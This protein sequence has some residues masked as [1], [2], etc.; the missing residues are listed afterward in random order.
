MDFKQIILDHLPDGV[1]V[2]DK[3][4]AA[5]VKDIKK[6]VGEE[7]IPKEWYSKKTIE[8]EKEK[9][10]LETAAGNSEGQNADIEAVRTALADE[11]KA[12]AATKETLE[13]SIAEEKAA[14]KATQADYAAKEQ[15]VTTRSKLPELLAQE[16]EDEWALLPDAV[17]LAADDFDLQDV[18]LDKDG[19]ISNVDEIRAKVREKYNAFGGTMKTKKADVGNPQQTTNSAKRFSNNSKTDA[20][21]EVNAKANQA[22]REFAG[23]ST[24]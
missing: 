2:S 23:K 11:K 21:P 1:E 15:A 7:T 6:V 12:H 4:M 13:K 5:I 3:T 19:N 18:T 14:H 22:F 8:W 20:I 9:S 24:E 16:Y 10:A 17:K